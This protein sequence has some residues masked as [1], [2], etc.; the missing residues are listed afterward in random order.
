MDGAWTITKSFNKEENRWEFIF[1][2]GEQYIAQFLPERVK[3]QEET[4]ELLINL[5]N[6]CLKVLAENKN[7]GDIYG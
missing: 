2:N 3:T 1:H 6:N 4:I 5:F 7:T